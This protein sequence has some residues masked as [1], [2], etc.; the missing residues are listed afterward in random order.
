M[1]LP[2][3]TFRGF[4]A[5]FLELPSRSLGAAQALSHTLR[6]RRCDLCRRGSG[7]GGD[8]AISPGS[9]TGLPCRIE[10]PGEVDPSGSLCRPPPTC[11]GT[12]YAGCRGGFS[13]ITG[14]QSHSSSMNFEAPSQRTASKVWSSSTFPAE[15]K[16]LAPGRNIRA[17]RR[18]ALLNSGVG[19]GT[20]WG[21]ATPSKKDSGREK[22]F[23]KS[24]KQ[25]GEQREE[26]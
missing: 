10:S 21:S 2:T 6:M 16:Y 11:L 18:A 24:E 22:S 17:S 3:L 19:T 7:K 15:M 20:F 14:N 5:F 8:V 25:R 4:F 13:P 12:N 23:H 9:P 26:T 1:P